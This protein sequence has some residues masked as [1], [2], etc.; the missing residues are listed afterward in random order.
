M[1][2]RLS[3]DTVTK[4]ERLARCDREIARCEAELRA[5]HLEVEGLAL[6]LADWSAERRLILEETDGND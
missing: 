2:Y 1:F 3:A 4:A 6:G 5:G